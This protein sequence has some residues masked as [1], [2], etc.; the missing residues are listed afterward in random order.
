MGRT[1][2]FDETT[3]VRRA[4]AAFLDTGFEGTSV[5]DLV[6]AT[7]LHRGSLYQAFGSK[8][9]IFLTALRQVLDQDGAAAPDTL[10]LLLVAALELSPHDAEVR[11]LIAGALLSYPDPARTLGN[12]L[13]ERAQLTEEAAS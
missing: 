2:S 1:R 8:R 13:L 4:A 3:T 6:K 10:D 9:G 7:G 11:S 5:D 12:R